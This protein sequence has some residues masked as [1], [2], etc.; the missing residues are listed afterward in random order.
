MRRS[1]AWSLFGEIVRRFI[2][3]ESVLCM[4]PAGSARPCAYSQCGS[5]IWRPVDWASRGRIGYE[6]N[7]ISK[8]SSPLG[9]I[10]N[11]SRENWS[12]LWMR[13]SIAWSPFGEIVRRFI[14]TESVLCM[15]PAGS[16]R[17]CAYSQCGSWIWRPVDWASRGRIGYEKNSISKT[18]SPL[19]GIINFSRE[20]WSRLWMR[21]SI[22]WSP[23]GEIVRR[24][25][26]LDFVLCIGPA[27]SG[28][29]CAYSRCGSWIWRPID[30][31][32]HGR[33]G[34]KKNPYRQTSSSPGLNVVCVLTLYHDCDGKVFQVQN[35]HCGT[36]ISHGCYG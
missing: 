1:I 5:W 12:R 24:F 8:T 21:R 35:S 32:S 26:V 29:P 7:S 23:F 18:S 27:V 16:A 3:T 25:V 2:V 22:A 13:R 28:R 10:I 19:G 20:N 34:Y 17:P 11:F 36:W 30:W 6:K 9:G 31:P 33:I 15:G 4:G 14:V